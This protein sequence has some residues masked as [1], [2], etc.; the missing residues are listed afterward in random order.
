MKGEVRIFL[1]KKNKAGKQTYVALPPG[2]YSVNREHL[3]SFYVSHDARVSF[4]YK[5]SANPK[6]QPAICEDS[7]I[8]YIPSRNGVQRWL[9]R[10]W[11]KTEESEE[12]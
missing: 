10:G 8:A 3:Q 6:V 11:V 7:D 4:R 9:R 12:Q 1:Y 5:A 2:T